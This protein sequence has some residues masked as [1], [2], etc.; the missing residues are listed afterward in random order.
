MADTNFRMCWLFDYG[1][2]LFAIV[3]I[4]A[5]AYHDFV[6]SIVCHWFMIPNLCIC[7]WNLNE[8]NILLKA[9]GKFMFR[10][11]NS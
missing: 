6:S 8:R 10:Y 11:I 1:P 4:L 3:L 5:I 2:I 9:K 7:V